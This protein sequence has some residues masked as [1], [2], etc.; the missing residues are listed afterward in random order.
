MPS[1]PPSL[2]KSLPTLAAH[3]RLRDDPL[4]GAPTLLYPEGALELDEIAA[5]IVRRCDGRRTVD[6]IV[7]ELDTLFDGDCGEIAGDVADYL[8]DLHGRG[9][10]VFQPPVA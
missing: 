3:A 2:E 9:L 8:R 4:T 6:A 10:V 7:A 5:E 1:M